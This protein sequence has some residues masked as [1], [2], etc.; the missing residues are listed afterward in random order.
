MKTTPYSQRQ[1]E[2]PAIR[3]AVVTVGDELI[4]GERINANEKWLLHLLWERGYPAQIAFSLPDDVHAIASWIRR[5][6]DTGHYPVLVSGG[7]GGTHDDLTREGIAKALDVP[8]TKHEECFRILETRYGDRL[9]AERQRM[10]WLP[11]G[12]ELIANPLG[13]PGFHIQ[14]VFAFPGF[15]NMLQ[16]MILDVL[17]AILPD[18]SPLQWVVREYMLPV[19]EGDIAEEVG[20]FVQ[21]FPQVHIGIYPEAGKRRGVVIRLRCS[22]DRKELMDAFDAFAEGLRKTLV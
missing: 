1:G 11:Q 17:P 6:L 22:N 3:P 5:L 14:G 10:A 4:F 2:H 9:N 20:R 15:P 8:L 19:A 21:R 7:L 18:K 13:A 16:P 12:C